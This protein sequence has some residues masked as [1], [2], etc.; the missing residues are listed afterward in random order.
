VT[1]AAWQ[2][3]GALRHLATLGGPVIWLLL[4]MAAFAVTLILLKAWQILRFNWQGRTKLAQ[5]LS[6]WHAGHDTR[7]IELLHD[8]RHP[9]G[10]IL[11]LAM[12]GSAAPAPLLRDELQRLARAALGNLQSWMRALELVAVT[13]PLL[14]LLGTV[15]GMVEAFRNLNEAGVQADPGLLSSGIWQALLTT[16]AGLVVAVPAT[17][18]H[19]WLERRIERLADRLQDQV[20]QVFTRDLVAL[21]SPGR[22]PPRLPEQ[23]TPDLVTPL[24]RR[25]S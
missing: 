5:A 13:A 12:K 8:A 4:A 22:V 15:L 2:A 3:F 25:R 1:E 23:V 14:G 16:A 17:L 19:G 20:T 7:A 24:P 21:H 10:R 9:A 6:Q 11:L 18:G